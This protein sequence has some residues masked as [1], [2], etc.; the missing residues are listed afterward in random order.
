MP[1]PE[2]IYGIC[3]A[4]LLGAGALMALLGAI[5][6]RHW[7][8][9]GFIVLPLP[10]GIL[11]SDRAQDGLSAWIGWMLAVVA[12]TGFGGWWLVR[13]G[14][15]GW[16]GALMTVTVALLLAGLLGPFIAPSYG[17]LP[18]LGWWLG[19]WMGCAPTLFGLMAG[20]LIGWWQKRRAI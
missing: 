14:Y 19:L 17:F 20:G 12:A 2:S 15:F 4:V 9:V 8:I 1:D 5:A 16:F 7:L 11:L 10:V 13:A 6:G 3:L 18:N